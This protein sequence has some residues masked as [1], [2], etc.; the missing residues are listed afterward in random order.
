MRRVAE[1]LS[2]IEELFDRTSTVSKQEY[3]EDHIHAKKLTPIDEFLIL[4]VIDTPG[5]QLHEIQTELACNTGTCINTSTVCRFLYKSGF[6]RKKLQTVALQC[7]EESRQKFVQEITVYNRDLFVF[8]DET[9]SER[10]DS[11]HRYGY[12]L[13]GNLPDP[14]NC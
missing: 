11:L 13:R 9:G 10:R 5:I 14:R 1:N 2:R 7:S 3:P 6:T 4:L 8:V 12:S